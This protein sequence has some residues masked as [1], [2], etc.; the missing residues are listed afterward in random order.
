MRTFREVTRLAPPS[1]YVDEDLGIARKIAPESFQFG[2]KLRMV[3]NFA[4]QS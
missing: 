4:V 3:V 1:D 2:A